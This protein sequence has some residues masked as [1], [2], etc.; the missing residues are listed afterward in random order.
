MINIFQDCLKA[1][2]QKSLLP[3]ANRVLGSEEDAKDVV[4]DVIFKLLSSAP[5]ISGNARSYLIR[6]VIN[7]A[8]NLKKRK[9]GSLAVD[10]AII[11]DPDP[12]HLLSMEIKKFLN[13]AFWLL[14]RYLNPREFVV[15]ILR[16]GFSYAYD[17]IAVMLCVTAVQCRKL[18]SRAKRKVLLRE[19]FKDT[20][21]PECILDNLA[22]AVQYRMMDTATDLLKNIFT[23]T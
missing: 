2:Y 13:D 1:D 17:E 16:E 6:S 5:N 10:P 23:H 11:P 20:P 15:F 8:I 14:S 4:Q 21:I 3:Y 18:L 12:S 22:I 9:H 7:Q 19:T